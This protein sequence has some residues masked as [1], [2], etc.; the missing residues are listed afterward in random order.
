[1]AEPITLYGIHGS[2]P[3]VTVQAGLRIK[4]LEYR[5]VDLPYGL[6]PLL[7][8]ARFGKRTVPGLTVGAQKVVGSRLILRALD[9]L[10]PDPPFM[11]ADPAHRLAVDQA[12]QWGDEVFQEHVRWIAILGILGEP[13]VAPAYGSRSLPPL[14]KRAYGPATVALFNAE[15][16]ILGHPPDRVR[17]EYLPALPGHLDH[18]DGLIADGVI[19]G[20]Q[21]NVADLQFAG[22]LRLLLTMED[23]REAIDARPCGRLARKLVPEYDGAMPR[24]V[25]DSPL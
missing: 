18:I 20:E 22:S 6:S 9:G 21:P 24:G 25:V 3:C 2:H 8:T 7:Q 1:V 16:R 13:S 15:M 12:D 5:T 11:P 17:S 19:G 23:L 4:G 14:P 10:A